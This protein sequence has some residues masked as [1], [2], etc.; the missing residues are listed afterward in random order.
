MTRQ[1]DSGALLV[2]GAAVLWGTTGTAQ[3]FAP[4]GAQ[5]IAVG[6][7]RLVIGGLALLAFAASQGLLRQVRDLPWAP[8]LLAAAAMAGYQLCFFA[9]VKRTGV[10]VG[11][12]VAIGSAPI[13]AGLLGVVLQREWPGNHWG[14]ATLMAVA[15]CTLLTLAGSG[16]AQIEPLGL[17]L[18][19][20]AGAAY[21]TYALFSKR[22]LST[23]PP[24]LAAAAVFFLGGLILTPLLLITDLHWLKSV[25]GSA[26]AL[27]LGLIATAAAYILFTRGLVTTPAA[28]A[29]TLSLGEP[30]VA[31]LLGVFVL[32]E[33]LTPAAWLGVLLVFA[34]LVWLTVGRPGQSKRPAEN[35]HVP[36]SESVG[37]AGNQEFAQE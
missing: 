30:V 37:E 4:A 29:V 5:P 6:T 22:I 20:G 32:G 7:V 9:A 21:A 31:S 27:E 19:L 3:A 1:L 34:G 24:D 11:T 14:I 36:S 35:L 18:A 8:T 2:L 13:I 12:V 28:T 23:V 26:V 17:L 10:A 16:G 25:R 33:Q 15:G